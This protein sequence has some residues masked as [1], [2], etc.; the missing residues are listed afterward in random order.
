MR[1]LFGD[2]A[3]AAKGGGAVT[4]HLSLPA[5]VGMVRKGISNTHR[6][7]TSSGV[8]RSERPSYSLSRSPCSEVEIPLSSVVRC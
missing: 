5:S 1:V 6:V 8:S 3:A 2:G 4:P 7:V